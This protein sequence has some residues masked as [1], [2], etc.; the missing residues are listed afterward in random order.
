[1]IA[2][3][4]K[5]ADYLNKKGYN[6]TQDMIFDFLRCMSLMPENGD[7]WENIENIMRPLFCKSPEQ[8]QRFSLDFELYRKGVTEEDIEEFASKVPKARKFEALHQQQVHLRNELAECR[9]VLLQ[10][11]DREQQQYFETYPN[12]NRIMDLY[13]KNKKGIRKVCSNIDVPEIREA[14]LEFPRFF[15]KDVM[16]SIP[17]AVKKILPFAMMTSSAE[18][19]MEYLTTVATFYKNALSA[20]NESYH[21]L[22]NLQ[23]ELQKTNRKMEDINKS[24]REYMGDIAVKWESLNHRQEFLGKGY[25]WGF[26]EGDVMEKKFE[27]LTVQEMEKVKEYLKSNLKKFRTRIEKR[28]H[29]VSKKRLDM[30]ETIKRACETNGVP[31]RLCYEQPRNKTKLLLFLDISGSC[32]KASEL[33]F[34]F[35]QCLCDLFPGGVQCFMFVNRLYDV[36]DFFKEEKS[37]EQVLKVIPTKGVYSD[38]GTPLREFCAEYWNKLTKDSIIFFIGDARGNKHDPEEI[39]FKEI[40]RKSK[41]CY[42]LN[43]ENQKLWGKKDSD[44]EVYLPYLEAMKQATTPMELLLAISTI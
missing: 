5:L 1:M 7:F 40:A 36:T 16:E 41:K 34:F 37:M 23:D 32:R 21:A 2:F 12:V 42:W 25:V 22:S 4:V 35:M 10:T 15:N 20:L 8:N 28:I 27:D 43:T 38:Y 14:V 13:E 44:T 33:M 11:L 26:D 39:C 9:N 30:P 19:V 29:T 18:E 3:I 31:I 24:Y 17:A 6:V